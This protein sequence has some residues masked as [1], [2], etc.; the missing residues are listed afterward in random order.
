MKREGVPAC[1]PVDESWWCRLKERMDYL[2]DRASACIVSINHQTPDGDGDF[3]I[4]GGDGITVTGEDNG[5]RIEAAITE[6]TVEGIVGQEAA[7]RQQADQALQADIDAE[8]QARISADNALRADIATR[9]TQTALDAE[10]TA[11][12]QADSKLQR[13][14][15]DKNQGSAN[16]GKVLIVGGDGTVAPGTSSASVAWGG[17]SGELADQTDLSDALAGKADDADVVHKSGNET[18]G[19]VKTFDNTARCPN[20][21]GTS[22]GEE[23]VNAASLNQWPSIVRTVGNQTIAGTKTFV[24]YPIIT[25][26]WALL[27]RNDNYTIGSDSEYTAR[28]IRFVDAN[29][30]LMTSIRSEA[31][32]NAAA[33]SRVN[34]S[35]IS[36]YGPNG[37]SCEL[38]L[39]ITD[40]GETQA[41]L[42]QPVADCRDNQIVTA[43]WV[44]DHEGPRTYTAARLQEILA[45]DNYYIS[46]VMTA[47]SSSL[48]LHSTIMAETVGGTSYCG[49]SLSS[50]ISPYL[51]I[52]IVI[53]LSKCACY[54]RLINDSTIQSAEIESLKGWVYDSNGKVVDP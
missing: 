27:S 52:K 18:I 6:E 17:I 9:A 21:P 24:N 54:Y 29:G 15:I 22:T 4:A 26:S 34:D 16:A 36:N 50:G 44:R 14:K 45:S 32:G 35:V 33:A 1:G 25:N 11:R 53:N 5:I 46:G 41:L 2:W 51:G 31:S 42:T 40:S 8:E 49:F 30:D 38:R 39:R 20:I 23:I 43:G 37:K 7:A 48:T 10:E 3:A 47:T 13:D 19:G 28:H 12:Q